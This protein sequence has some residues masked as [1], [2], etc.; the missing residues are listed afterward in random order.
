MNSTGW[1]KKPES[2]STGRSPSGK[3]DSHLK[4]L[5]RLLQI[6]VTP[7][8]AS[9]VGARSKDMTQQVDEVVLQQPDYVTLMIGGN[10]AC[11]W[12]G[13][14]PHKIDTFESNV[15]TAVDELVEANPQVKILLSP[16][17][18]LLQLKALGQAR[19][20]SG[21]EFVSYLS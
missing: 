21:L 18:D 16:L 13:T 14:K 1:G 7:F 5:R 19:G 4:R 15:S 12:D 9:V 8:N 10:D 2:W 11:S 20:V 17:P 6:P 3:V